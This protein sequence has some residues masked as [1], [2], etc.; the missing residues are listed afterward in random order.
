MAH[1]SQKRQSKGGYVK[2]P[3]LSRILVDSVGAP[4]ENV[5]LDLLIEDDAKEAT[6]ARLRASMNENLTDVGELL[7]ML[8]NQKSVSEKTARVDPTLEERVMSQKWFYRYELPSGRVTEQYIP[9]EIDHII[10]LG[11]EMMLAALQPDFQSSGDN[12]TAIDFSSHQGFFS[13]ALAKR[14]KSVLGLNISAATSN[15]RS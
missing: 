13:L 3:D 8:T 12:L 10:Q 15:R 9:D 2:L 14:C 6:S 1:K 7:Q 4:A 5:G 11:V